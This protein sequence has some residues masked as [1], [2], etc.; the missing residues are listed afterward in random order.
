MFYREAFKTA[1]IDGGVHHAAAAAHFAGV[2]ADESAHGGQGIVLADEPDGVRVSSRFHQRNIAGNVHAR[3]T[4][5]HAGN[6]LI[7]RAFAA[8]VFDVLDKVVAGIRGFL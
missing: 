4:L 5:R 3:G 1:N 8:P 6:G 7:E 2:F